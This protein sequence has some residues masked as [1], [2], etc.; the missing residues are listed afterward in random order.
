MASLPEY[1]TKTCEQA[2]KAVAP[3]AAG[4]QET[5]QYVHQKCGPNLPLDRIAAVPEEVPQVQCLLDL[6]E[7]DLDV[8]AGDEP[9]D[10]L[11]G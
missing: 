6:L 11:P 7:E 10:D 3:V 8:P 1:S 5:K 4:V 9:G 2:G